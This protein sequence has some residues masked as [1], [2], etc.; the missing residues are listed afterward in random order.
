MGRTKP[1]GRAYMPLRMAYIRT[2]RNKILSIVLLPICPDLS[3][4]G[5]MGCLDLHCPLPQKGKLRSK[6]SLGRAQD[7]LLTWLLFR[8]L[9]ASNSL[10]DTIFGLIVLPCC[11]ICASLLRI[12]VLRFCT[13][14]CFMCASL[15]PRIAV[16]CCAPNNGNNTIEFACCCAIFPLN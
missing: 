7:A 8:F 15:M 16:H 11:T 5:P 12:A 3:A 14:I 1:F 13:S 4:S 6:Y 9:I 2:I 10:H